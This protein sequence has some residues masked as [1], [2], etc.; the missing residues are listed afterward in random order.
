MG[1]VIPLAWSWSLVVCIRCCCCWA[2]RRRRLD[3]WTL[4]RREQIRAIKKRTASAPKVSRSRSTS[5]L[6]FGSFKSQSIVFTVQCIIV[7]ISKQAQ[8]TPLYPI[9]Y[10]HTHKKSHTYARLLPLVLLPLSPPPGLPRRD[11]PAQEREGRALEADARGGRR[12]DT[13]GVDGL[14][15]GVVFVLEAEAREGVVPFGGMMIWFVC[16]VVDQSAQFDRS[17]LCVACSM[18]MVCVVVNVIDP[19]HVPCCVSVFFRRCG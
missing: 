1:V 14:D 17:T 4:A 8:P 9:Q 3:V 2:A 10:S 6:V 19:L 13:Q 11:R 18:V 16:C 7:P 12:L 5:L 15:G